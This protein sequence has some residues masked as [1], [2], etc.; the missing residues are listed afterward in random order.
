MSRCV[1]QSRL[2]QENYGD[3]NRKEILGSASRDARSVDSAVAEFDELDRET[4]ST[5][6]SLIGRSR[7]EFLIEQV[8]L[9]MASRRPAT[10]AARNG[11]S[12]PSHR[13]S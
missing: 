10:G 5:T 2:V 12:A 4:R 9:W 3:M 13:V 7:A 8:G 11:T 1:G 6:S